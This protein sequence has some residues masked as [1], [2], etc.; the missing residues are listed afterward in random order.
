MI[1]FTLTSQTQTLERLWFDSEELPMLI[2]L[3]RYA[4]TLFIALATALSARGATMLS[5]S[6]GASVS[7]V[8]AVPVYTPTSCSATSQNGARGNVS[9]TLSSPLSGSI[10]QYAQSSSSVPLFLAAAGEGSSSVSYQLNDTLMFFGVSQIRA[11]LIGAGTRGYS[12]SSLGSLGLTYG[13]SGVNLWISESYQM[14]PQTFSP[15]NLPVYL[16]FSIGGSNA[17]NFYI[18]SSGTLLTFSTG[19]EG[20]DALGNLVPL[21]Y[22][23][24]NGYAYG[25]GT[26]IVWDDAFDPPS[27]AAD[28]VPEPGSFLLALCGIG[29]IE[30]RRRRTRLR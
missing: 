6:C 24:K 22:A 13:S 16:N 4:G 23:S 10:S 26:Q 30:W 3:T 17:A 9:I 28:P 1:C 15:N 12:G 20:L 21:T 11:V 14:P 8:P 5:F 29:V 2:Q 7:G 25:I 18:G 19:I 27:P